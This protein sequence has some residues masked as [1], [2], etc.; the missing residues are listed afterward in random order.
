MGDRAVE[1]VS[2]ALVATS[3]MSRTDAHNE[4]LRLC[5]V[6]AK[7]YNALFERADD[8]RRELR[9]ILRALAHDLSK[10]RSLC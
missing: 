2:E 6:T 8:L 7:E 3:R 1:G 4:A 5:G 10:Q 9:P